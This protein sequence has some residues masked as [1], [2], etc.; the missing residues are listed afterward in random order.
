MEINR[1]AIL[2]ALLNGQTETIIVPVC[3]EV[4]ITQ[5]NLETM[6]TQALLDECQNRKE[7]KFFKLCTAVTNCPKIEVRLKGDNKQ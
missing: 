1:Y 6:L 2:T 4:G 3:Y 5:N 7:I